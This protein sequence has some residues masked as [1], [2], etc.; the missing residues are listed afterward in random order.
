MPLLL[1]TGLPGYPGICFL[2]HLTHHHWSQY[3]A[4]YLAINQT[5][6]HMPTCYLHTLLGRSLFWSHQEKFPTDC[7]PMVLS[8]WK[9]W[10][11]PYLHA[12][13][14]AWWMV[15]FPFWPLNPSLFFLA[16]LDPHKMEN[17]EANMSL[18]WISPVLCMVPLFWILIYGLSRI[19]WL[20][21]PIFLLPQGLLCQSTSWAWLCCVAPCDSASSHIPWC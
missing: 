21:K 4:L 14:E 10:R 18:V 19:L 9:I 15:Y 16:S 12:C 2:H 8:W 20:P 13:V 17:S 5:M 3:Q 1:V 11:M 6:A 7:L